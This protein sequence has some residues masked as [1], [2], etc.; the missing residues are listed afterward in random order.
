MT[1]VMKCKKLAYNIL[2]SECHINNAHNKGIQWFEA[3]L[4]RFYTERF[5]KTCGK[6]TAID[7]IITLVKNNIKSYLQ[8]PWIASNY[9]EIDAKIL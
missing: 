9:E 2:F 6:Q 7:D 8:S 3:Y 4:R 5:N 1:Y